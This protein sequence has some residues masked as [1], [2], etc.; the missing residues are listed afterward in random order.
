M[1]PTLADTGADRGS[2]DRDLG[3]T[4]AEAVEVDPAADPRH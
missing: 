2:V 4:D 3:E 1:P